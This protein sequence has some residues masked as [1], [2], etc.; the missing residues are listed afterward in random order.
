MCV[1]HV[2]LII[3]HIFTNYSVHVTMQLH[4]LYFFNVLQVF[5][6]NILCFCGV[7]YFKGSLFKPLVYIYSKVKKIYICM[8]SDF[9]LLF[10]KCL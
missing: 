9:H 4:L 8:F 10:I 2:L 6:E 5:Y 3:G 1:W 7:L